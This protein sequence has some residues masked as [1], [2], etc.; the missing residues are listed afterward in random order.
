MT[1]TVTG[2]GIT[3]NDSTVQT[4][5]FR[6]Q[7]PHVLTNSASVAVD[8]SL[9]PNF[10]M[11]LSVATTTLQAPTNIAAGF[12]G[13]FEI[14]QDGNG[15]RTLLFADTVWEFPDGNIPY[16]HE[17]ENTSTIFEYYCP[18]ASSVVIT[19][20][21]RNFKEAET[22]TALELHA[23]LGDS[24][25]NGAFNIPSTVQA[26]DFM[27]LCSGATGNAPIYAPE[28]EFNHVE[29]HGWERI[30]LRG[31]T[32]TS[33]GYGIWAKIA[34][35]NEAGQRYRGMKD[36][37]REYQI[38]YVF[39]GPVRFASYTVN[40]SSQLTDGNP[41]GATATIGSTSFDRV[42]VGMVGTESAVP[43]FSGQ[44]PTLT[45]QLAG[46]PIRAGINYYGVGVA[47]SNQ[48]VDMNDQGSDNFRGVATFKLIRE[49]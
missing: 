30:V 3:F 42:A 18:D 28:W 7:T 45:N 48:F 31:D 21:V 16:V 29:R 10:K 35:E 24:N 36:A 17:F 12:T 39:R 46:Q 25:V 8:M 27:V 4:S 38:L 26:G 41:S 19:K 14:I 5:A 6:D 47:G 1:T 33:S 44:T 49:T 11:T 13:T 15:V 37:T 32:G 40:A 20:V 23:S 34:E 22:P 9:G 2:T 43:T